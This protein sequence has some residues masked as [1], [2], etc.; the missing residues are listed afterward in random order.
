ML[1]AVALTFTCAV[2]ALTAAACG[3]SA[4][5]GDADPASLVPADA[6]L[7]VQA[8]LRPADDRRDGA[9]AAAGKVLRTDDPAG[10]LQQLF[11]D[12]LADEGE[13]LTWARDFAPWV[14]EEAGLTVSDLQADEPSYALVIA[15]KDAEAARATLDKAARTGDTKFVKRSYDGIDYQV[16]DDG[17]AVGLVDDF[18]VIA[19]EKAFKRTADM[20]DGGKALADSDRYKDAIDDLADDRL[21]LMFVDTKTI[22]DA[23]L[24]EDPAAAA[25]FE[26]F[27]AFLPIDEL[28]PTVASLQADGDAIVVDAATTG[29]PEGPFRTLVGLTSGGNTDLMA[30]L[31]GDAWGAFALPKLGET[32]KTMFSSFAGAIGGAAA[33]AEVKR[34]T[35]LDLEQDVFSWIGDSGV[36]IRGASEPE[37]DGALV[38]ESTDDG[39]AAPAFGKIVG[40]IGKEDGVRPEPVQ[41]E[42]AES[43]FSFKSPDTDKPIVLARG[44]GR[45]VAAYGEDAA[46]AALD[47][48]TK[49]GDGEIYAD[50]K[51]ALEDGMEPGFLLSMPAVLKLV[52]AI[53]EADADYDKA[54][55]YLEAL[56]AIASGGKV[57][58]DTVKSRIAVTL[59]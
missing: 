23:S 27:K 59:K 15:T 34:S 46:K 58:G 16:G 29:V 12:A 55:P 24:A 7:Y 11:D 38:I 22:V 45:V 57:D 4:S 5:G 14:G 21:G 33:A 26:Q 18:V 39:K 13:D 25:Q 50:A 3:E 2:L 51:D 42:G 8:S 43:A 54:K 41:L 47:P 44:A 35:G 6:G 40:L 56:N 31:P 49:L 30:D 19:S 52:D 1:R 53:G 28:G 32:A 9:L 48:A 36:F 10:R 37:L 20:R 17:T